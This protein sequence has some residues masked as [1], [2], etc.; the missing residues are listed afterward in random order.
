M[1]EDA[2]QGPLGLGEK[3]LKYS[4]RE[5]V[6]KG[7]HAWVYAG[8]DEFFDRDVA[9]KLLHRPGGVTPDMLRRGR[10]EAQLLSRLRHP[11]V[12]E[13][14]DAGITDAGQLY[15]VMELLR[16][17]TLREILR[18][19]R[20][21][22]PGETL[23]LFLQIADGVEAAHKLGAIHRDLKPENLFVLAGG[24]PKILDFGIAKVVDSAGWSTAKDVINGTILYMSPEQLQGFR[25]TVR[26]DVYAVGLMLY[27]A[28]HGAHPCLLSN[29]SP[30]VREL[31]LIQRVKQ[32]P[33][34]SELDPSIPRHVARAVARAMEKIPEKRVQSMSE[35]RAALATCL[36][37][38]TTDGEA[39]VVARTAPPAASPF[40]E[41]HDT[42]PLAPHEVFGPSPTPQLGGTPPPAEPERG[43][44][45]RRTHTA[46]P[47]ITDSHSDLSAAEVDERRRALRRVVVGGAVAGTLL[48]L[49][50]YLVLPK[51]MRVAAASVVTADLPRAA[52]TASTTAGTAPPETAT[53]ASAAPDSS[54]SAAPAV[55]VAPAGTLAPASVAARAAT[56]EP[57][58]RAAVPAHRAAP[59]KHDAPGPRDR[60]VWI[61]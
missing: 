55:S 27:E 29:P 36:E 8:R 3:F 33:L 59:K 14:V 7:G 61:E 19:R 40:V 18:T 53:P 37:R 35:L 16:G 17:R 30:T 58:P 46:P 38:L 28:L 26:S 10:A 39:P 54:H 44:W 34:L 56:A 31:A 51:P 9:I 12:V 15:I 23:R 4:I 60:E 1:A 45:D 22:A 43:S 20:R 50:L 52:A 49:A 24:T 32:P 13:V 21:L 42:E 57:P 48:G 47:V 6:G 25:A 2:Q 5:I 41:R 11:N